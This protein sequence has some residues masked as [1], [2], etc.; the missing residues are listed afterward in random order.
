MRTD[1]NMKKQK[2]FTFIEL[3]LVLIVTA[4]LS[5]M[6]LKRDKLD[7][8]QMRAKADGL[9]IAQINNAIRKRLADEGTGAV[10]ATY[11]GVDWLHDTTCPGGLASKIYLPCEISGE[12]FYRLT[13]VTTVTNSAGDVSASTNFG[14]MKTEGRDRG[15]LAALAVLAANNENIHGETP[16]AGT[17]YSYQVDASSQIIASSSY[18]TG[19]D[20]WLRVDG[21]NAMTATLDLGDN[22]IKNLG[23]ATA[24][25]ACSGTGLI[26]QQGGAILS[27]VGG[28]WKG[29]GSDYWRDP[30]TSYANLPT[31]DPVGTVRLSKDTGRAYRWTGG[32]WTAL[33]VDQNGDMNVPNRMTS[34]DILTSKL[35]DKQNTGYYLDPNST[36]RLNYA[37][38][39]VAKL[40]TNYVEGAACTTKE[41]G[42]TSS[43]DLMSCVGGVW[44]KSGGGLN[45]V[46][47]SLSGGNY[48]GQ[49][50][51]C[52]AGYTM[53]GGGCGW[54][55]D[56]NNGF[57]YSLPNGNGWYCADYDYAI[58]N[59][60]RV[61]CC[62]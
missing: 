8:D 40:T 36:S 15:D 12:F 33:A 14:I 21:T 48:H 50:L 20:Q 3:T 26:A 46:T 34:D 29:Q 32:S 61:R 58:V 51:S 60:I 7:A 1:K 57:V 2:G 35:Y 47:K 59:N 19:L 27:C 31:S 56:G 24:G 17:F 16:I 28:V 38:M 39:N 23:T 30:V 25:A 41:V 6:L 42:T 55:S 37:N 11:T 18:D 49:T 13:P 22:Q 5:M 45:C 4:V 53:T 10:A 52:D 62:Q 43:G 44:K 9:M 54:R